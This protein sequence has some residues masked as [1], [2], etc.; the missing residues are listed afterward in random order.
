MIF[1]LHPKIYLMIALN[2]VLRHI[3]IHFIRLI[4]GNFHKHVCWLLFIK[5]IVGT[6]GIFICYF[7]PARGVFRANRSYII[8]KT[9]PWKL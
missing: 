5:C 9:R 1:V 8:G 6:H 7:S 4:I 3:L 2:Y